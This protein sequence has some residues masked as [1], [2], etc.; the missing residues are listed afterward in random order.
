VRYGIIASSTSGRIGVVALWSRQITKVILPRARRECKNHQID[1]RPTQ[2]YRSSIRKSTVD[3]LSAACQSRGQTAILTR[4]F[5]L[6]EI[7]YFSG[8]RQQ[9]FKCGLRIEH[10][11]V[12]VPR[13]FRQCQSRP[14]GDWFPRIPAPLPPYPIY[15]ELHG[16][17]STSG[18]TS[19]PSKRS[20]CKWTSPA[21]K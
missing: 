9:V 1:W 2:K 5:W 3:R 20:Y 18:I 11:D 6:L 21:S 14:D 8:T 13:S 19:S 12:Q 15:W 10:G 16:R 7:L 4:Q 17:F